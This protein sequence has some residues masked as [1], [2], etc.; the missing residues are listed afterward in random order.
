[1]TG[2]NESV[3][4]GVRSKRGRAFSRGPRNPQRH[5]QGGCWAAAFK[6]GKTSGE[7]AREAGVSVST[8]HSRMA[9]WAWHE[10]LR[11]GEDGGQS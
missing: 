6:A 7:I 10:F 5:E 8:V 2:S 3:R 11:A 4:S 9:Q 1:M